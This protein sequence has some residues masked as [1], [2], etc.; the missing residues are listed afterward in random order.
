MIATR[1]PAGTVKRFAAALFMAVILA[2]VA[3]RPGLADEV[4]TYVKDGAAIGGIDP[5][6]YFT[7]GKPVAGSDA[8]TATHDGVTWKF[9]TAEHRDMFEADPQKYTPAYGGYCATGASFGYKIP[10]DPATWD[11][12]AGRLYLNA[13]PAPHKRYLSDVEGTIGRAD[14]NWKKIRDVPADKL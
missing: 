10:I 2:M 1:F 13:G 14:E 9:A 7:D 3:A 5:V 11:I 8:F 12:H 6:A 4:S